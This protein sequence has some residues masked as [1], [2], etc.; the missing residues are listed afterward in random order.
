MRYNKM[1][2]MIENRMDI[3]ST[4]NEFC[5]RN[6][7]ITWIGYNFIGVSLKNLLSRIHDQYREGDEWKNAFE[8]LN[9]EEIIYSF[10]HTDMER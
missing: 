10:C 8:E 9:A 1:I 2:V 5:Y 6:R 3:L 7:A 4:E